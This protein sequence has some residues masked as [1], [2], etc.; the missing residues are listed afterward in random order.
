MSSMSM[1]MLGAI[2]AS[3][4]AITLMFMV[5]YVTNDMDLQMQMMGMNTEFST[6]SSGF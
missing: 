5:S 6:A 2:Y 4:G 1:Y 3:S